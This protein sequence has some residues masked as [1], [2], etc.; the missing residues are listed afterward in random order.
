MAVFTHGE[1]EALDPTF[2]EASAAYRFL[3]RGEQPPAM[4]AN[5][6][7]VGTLPGTPPAA[8]LF[9]PHMPQVDVL[10]DIDGCFAHLRQQARSIKEGKRHVAIL[11]PGRMVIEWPVPEPSPHLAEVAASTSAVLGTDG[12]LDVSVI[13][14]TFLPAWLQDTTKTKCIPF[15]GILASWAYNGHTIVVF[16]GHSSAFEAGVRGSS[17]LLVDSGM[18]PFLQEGWDE[19][20]YRVMRPDAR[21]FLHDR[22]RYLLLQKLRCEPPAAA[23]PA[24]PDGEA[25]YLNCLLTTLAKA[26]TTVEFV[27]GRGVP[28]LAGLT[29]D[30]DERAWISRLPFRYESLNATEVINI[31]LREVAWDKRGLFK[32]QG[33]F[34]AILAF[35]GGASRDVAFRVTMSNLRNG[36]QRV[37][38]AKL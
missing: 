17:V 13:S 38:I 8:D 4:E 18:M 15:L 28:D 21:I 3:G 35:G 9:E 32:T 14:Y 24:E 29:N 30:R 27:S 26:P 34:R 16:E 11:T 22:Q 36:G 20:A 33:M 7:H 6:K 5:F 2:E 12:P 23:Q 25:S 10:D 1:L 37:K 19:L 31:L